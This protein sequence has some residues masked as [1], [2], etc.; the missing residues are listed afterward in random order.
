MSAVLAA[1]RGR[2]RQYQIRDQ[3]SAL[4]QAEESLRDADRRKDEFLAMLAHELRNPLAPDPH[5]Q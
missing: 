2:A 5:R 1:M 4:L 3:L